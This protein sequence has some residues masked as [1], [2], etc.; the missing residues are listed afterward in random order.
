MEGRFFSELFGTKKGK[1]S[2]PAPEL[3]AHKVT[4]P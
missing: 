3:E 1:I 4:L 2:A